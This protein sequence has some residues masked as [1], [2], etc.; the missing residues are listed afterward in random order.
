MRVLNLRF[1]LADVVLG[2]L[3]ASIAIAPAST[4]RAVELAE[5]APEV[6]EVRPGDT[7]W[8][9]AG[10]YLRDPWLWPEIWQAND[11]PGDPDL[12]YPGERLRLV[13]VEGRPR[14]VRDTAPGASG[15]MRV[16]RLS[17]RVR[18]SALEAPV[19]MIPVASI[20]PFLTQPWVADSDAIKRA[21]YVVGFGEDRTIAGPSDDVFVRRIDT[22]AV[23]AFQ[24]LRPGDALRDPDTNRILGYE[25]TFVAN[26][27]LER[28]GDPA[29]LRVTRSEREVA[30][31]DRVI[32]ASLEAPLE[33]FFPRA[34]PAGIRGQILSVMNGVSQIGQYDIVTINRG[35]DDRLQPGHVFE[36]FRGGEQVRDKVRAGDM[37]WN[38]K[39]ESP[40]TGSFW[41]GNEYSVKGW[42]E[43][44]TDSSAPIPLHA[45]IG[46]DRGTYI[47]P[48]QR[49]GLLM[50]FRCFDHVSFAL[51]LN[52]DRAMSV[53]DRVVPPAR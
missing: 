37:N 12:I 6:Y 17:P 3:I 7:L 41:L 24:I 31:G 45:D 34:A 40:L 15:D 5:D 50:V 51:V 33:N 22:A 29:I 4:V 8:S 44:P 32:P 19:P 23:G 36:I 46:R 13:H 26:A 10:R 18:V 20:A 38:W 11:D 28:V 14:V 16:V 43:S 2:A 47:R 53:G 27:M 49:T 48:M 52:A 25:A 30:I 35:S 21:P 1:T 9:I 39:S 42:S